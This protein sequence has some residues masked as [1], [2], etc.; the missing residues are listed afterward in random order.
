MLHDNQVTYSF[1]TKI[2]P[3]HFRESCKV[4]YE[5]VVRC[6]K[7]LGFDTKFSPL[8]NIT[9][10][11]KKVSGYAQTR[12]NNVLLQHRTILLGIDLDRMLEM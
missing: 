3:A 11:N 1:I 6:L 7:H 8:D 2:F 5:P 4:I 9:V 12:R 10:N